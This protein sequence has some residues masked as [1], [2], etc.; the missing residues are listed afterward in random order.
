M[1]KLEIEEP[2]VGFSQFKF[3][4]SKIAKTGF[5]CCLPSFE[6]LFAI[7]I[8]KVQQ[9]NCVFRRKFDLI[10]VQEPE[11]VFLVMLGTHAGYELVPS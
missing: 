11:A 2:K 10:G 6:L 1:K 9:S 8:C 3:L 7:R 5:L 4:K